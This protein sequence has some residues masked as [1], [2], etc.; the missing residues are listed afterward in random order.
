MNRLISLLTPVLFALVIKADAQSIT[1]INN[2]GRTLDYKIAASIENCD[3]Y[4]LFFAKIEAGVTVTHADV[5]RLIWTCDQR[6][7]HFSSFALT[8]NKEVGDCVK[9]NEHIAKGFATRISYHWSRD[10]QTQHITVTIND[11]AIKR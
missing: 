1:V 11:M 5:S 10:P 8:G 3:R 9:R 6:P 7:D 4:C 2:T